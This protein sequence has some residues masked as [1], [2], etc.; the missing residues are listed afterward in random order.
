MEGQGWVGPLCHA[1]WALGEVY[2]PV[3]ALR[4]DY[5]GGGGSCNSHLGHSYLPMLFVKNMCK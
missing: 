2:T 4:G 3:A 5:M 1:F